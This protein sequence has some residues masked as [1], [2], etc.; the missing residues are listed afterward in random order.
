MEQAPRKIRIL[1]ASFL[2]LTL[3]LPSAVHPEL[4]PARGGSA[5]G[6]EGYALRQAGLEESKAKGSFLRKIGY[7]AAER[8]GA[9]EMHRAAELIRRY[10]FAGPL[11]ADLSDGDVVRAFVERLRKG[12]PPDPWNAPASL[13]DLVT[14]PYRPDPFLRRELAGNPIEDSYLENEL[15]PLFRKTLETVA[16]RLK[17]PSESLGF[18]VGEELLRNLYRA[19]DESGNLFIGEEGIIL[20][21]RWAYRQFPRMMVDRFADPAV[22]AIAREFLENIHEGYNRQGNDEV[23]KTIR[24]F[25][26]QAGQ[27]DSSLIDRPELL[28]GHPERLEPWL[29]LAAA[30]NLIDASRA[31][32]HD[33]IQQQGNLLGYL[34]P[35]MKVPFLEELGGRKYL[36]EFARQ[37]LKPNLLLA[38]LTDN[39]AELAADLKTAEVLLSANRSL[40]IRMIVKGDNGAL[41]DASKADAEWTLSV[42]EGVPDIF[43]NLRAYRVEGRF[44]LIEGPRSHG[45][46]LEIAPA[47][48]LHALRQADLVLSKGEAN[49]WSLNGLKKP[50]FLLW[51]LKWTDG[52]RFGLGLDLPEE[53]RRTYPPAAVLLDGS[54]GLYFSNTLRIPDGGPSITLKEFLHPAAGAEEQDERAVREVLGLLRSGREEDQEAAA[55]Q[56]RQWLVK[57]LEEV[58]SMPVPNLEFALS[59]YDELRIFRERWRQISGIIA[60]LQPGYRRVALLHKIAQQEGM[61]LMESPPVRKVWVQWTEVG[62]A[63]QQMMTNLGKLAAPFLEAFRSLAKLHGG[64]P[65]I[66]EEQ[67]AEIRG[68]AKEVAGILTQGVS[69]AQTLQHLFSLLSGSSASEPNAAGA[70]EQPLVWGVSRFAL[71]GES[72]T[73]INVARFSPDGKFVALG[74]ENDVV[75]ILDPATG[76]FL[77]NFEVEHGRSVLDLAFRPD[78]ATLAVAGGDGKIHLLDLVAGGEKAVLEGDGEGDNQARV[79][80]NATGD[81]LASGGTGGLVHVWD[82]AAGKEKSR[83]Q[84]SHGK[85]MPDLAFS[86]DGQLLVSAG[87]RIVSIWEV[88]TQKLR[89]ILTDADSIPPVVGAI[90]FSPDGKTLAVGRGDHTVQLWDLETQQPRLVLEDHATLGPV[91]AVAFSPDGATLVAGGR[92]GILSVWDSVNGEPLFKLGHA[93]PVKSLAFSPDG[94]TLVSAG[95]KGRDEAG[96]NV[97]VWDFERIKSFAVPQAEAGQPLT[98]AMARDSVVRKIIQVIQL[99]PDPR[100]PLAGL[101]GRVDALKFLHEMGLLIPEEFQEAFGQL[102]SGGSQQAALLASTL[103]RMGAWTMDQLVDEMERLRDWEEQAKKSRGEDHLFG[104]EL[105]TAITKDSPGALWIQKLVEV[106]MRVPDNLDTARNLRIATVFEGEN[107][108]LEIQTLPSYSPET[109]ARIWELWEELFQR[110]GLEFRLTPWGFPLDDAWVHLNFNG[111]LSGPAL[112]AALFRW[113]AVEA[114][115]DKESGFSRQLRKT[116]PAG[117]QTWAIRQPRDSKLGGYRTEVLGMVYSGGDVRPNPWMRPLSRDSLQDYRRKLFRDVDELVWA[118]RRREQ[119]PEAWV[120]ATADLAPRALLDLG[121]SPSWKRIEAALQQFHDLRAQRPGDSL[122]G[123]KALQRLADSLQSKGIRLSSPDPRIAQDPALWRQLHRFL[124]QGT[125]MWGLDLRIEGTQAALAVP[126]MG[127]EPYEAYAGFVDRY[128]RVKFD[129]RNNASAV[130]ALLLREDGVYFLNRGNDL[131]EMVQDLW[132]PEGLHE[133]LKD[134][135]LGLA[136]MVPPGPQQAEWWKQLKTLLDPRTLREVIPLEAARGDTRSWG[137]LTGTVGQTVRDPDQPGRILPASFVVKLPAAGVEEVRTINAA[138]FFG[139]YHPALQ[140]LAPSRKEEIFRW[141]DY[142]GSEIREVMLPDR[143]T[144]YVRGEELKN[145]LAARIQNPPGVSFDWKLLPLKPGETWEKVGLILNDLGRLKSY[146]GDNPNGLPIRDVAEGE[147]ASLNA[148][149]LLSDALATLPQ[150]SVLLGAELLPDTQGRVRLILFSA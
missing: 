50:I 113:A 145:D 86:P 150:G 135:Q 125:P 139:E 100:V 22:W 120:L 75:E 56:L 54:Q 142:P 7:L 63:F 37:V 3:G 72:G 136:L 107:E 106:M 127:P 111:R 32:I 108:I 98:R 16:Q 128:L 99:K 18:S 87:R 38:Y 134:R 28:E 126:S 65:E 137:P 94:E 73:Q 51:R 6:G 77:S 15:I 109:G 29:A 5:S 40:K 88:K 140:T 21:Y 112:K 69:S 20:S 41:N 95:R 8:A 13:A 12:I 104:I 2:L 102:P 26:D 89:A 101:A 83:F 116:E 43:E 46:P 80:F 141:M 47:E 84:D 34:L 148:A 131:W 123:E 71:D 14:G 96:K 35:R 27:M 124:E 119:N 130:P 129:Q 133:F 143:I 25:L 114:E 49:A 97:Y 48:T 55:D 1:T 68:L 103:Y 117:Y 17:L 36:E 23:Q 122:T 92:G 93:G 132:L 105:H 149:L 70:E 90:A 67:Q 76:E 146:E 121:Y 115:M 62:I 118:F 45:M 64:M 110:E 91:D 61:S 147:A 11:S 52:T 9:E 33:A 79:A 30:S 81:L 4:V 144:F 82:P 138:E 39:N 10:E 78:G 42:R 53:V 59:D 60:N 74:G 24:R 66:V 57:P 19:K 58:A 31:E 85:Y 44:T